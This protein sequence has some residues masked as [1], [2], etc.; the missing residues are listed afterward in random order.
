[1]KDVVVEL[2]SP[3][4]WV[5]PPAMAARFGGVNARTDYMASI[6][7]EDAGAEMIEDS[8]AV[9]PLPGARTVGVVFIVA[10]WNYPYLT[11]INTWFPP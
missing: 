6:A 2:K 1:M 7:A 8:N 3:G 11:T 5:A 9:P 10:P 4:R